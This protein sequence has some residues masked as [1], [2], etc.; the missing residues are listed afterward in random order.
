MHCIKSVR[1]WTFMV[2]IFPHFAWIQMLENEIR[3]TPN[4]DTFYEMF[5]L[6]IYVYAK[7]QV[8]LSRHLLVQSSYWKRV[9]FVKSWRNTVSVSPLSNWNRLHSLFWCFHCWLWISKSQL[10]RCQENNNTKL[11]FSLFSCY[12]V[13]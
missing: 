9:K 10:G 3:K 7:V 2:H 11:I 12:W 5:V 8:L 4:T 1:I 13:Q 6:K